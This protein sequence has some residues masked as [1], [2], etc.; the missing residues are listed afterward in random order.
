MAKAYIADR[1]PTEEEILSAL[2][3]KAIASWLRRQRNGKREYSYLSNEDCLLNRVLRSRFPGVQ[4][5]IGA[6]ALTAKLPSERI[7]VHFPQGSAGPANKIA[8]GFPR[9]YSGALQ[10]CRT[11]LDMKPKT[12]MTPEFSSL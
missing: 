12:L 5:S 10:R 6:S 1:L 4:F 3:P 7:R 9:T 8:C 11:Y 2:E